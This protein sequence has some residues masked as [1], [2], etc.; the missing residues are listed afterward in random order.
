[1]RSTERQADAE[2]HRDP[3]DTGAISLAVE[4]ALAVRCFLPPRELADL[5][6]RLRGYVRVLRPQ[7][8]A[9]ADSLERGDPSWYL[10]QSSC[11]AA[12]RVLDEEPDDGL[13]TAVFRL[14]R[15]CGALLSYV[16]P[17]RHEDVT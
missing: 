8:Q 15:V 11:D 2:P 7:V 9:L 4:Q 17:Q 10:C 1:M 3:I 12:R 5:R 14:G 13:R 6:Y 16:Q